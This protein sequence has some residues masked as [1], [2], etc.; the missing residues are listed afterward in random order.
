MAGEPERI[1]AK[2]R[3]LRELLQNRRY[4]LDFYQREY[5]WG[6]RQIAELLEDLTKRFLGDYQEGHSRKDVASYSPYFLGSIV[7]SQRGDTRFLID[8]QQRLTS[9]TLLLI[10]L[11]HSLEPGE[12][13]QIAPLISSVH[14]GEHSFNLDVPERNACM[15][16]LF[17]QEQYDGVDP[18][19]SVANIIARFKDIEEWWSS[20]D[21][22]ARVLPFF[23]D[24]LVEKLILVEIVTSD[25]DMAYEIFET[26]ND[27]GLSLTPTEML[28]GY[29][30]SNLGAPDEVARADD[31]WRDEVQRLGE[32]DK[33]ADADF[34]KSWLRASY[35]ETIR[36]R[37]RDAVPQDYDLVGTQFHR[38]VRDNCESIGLS[39]RAAFARFV[40]RDF[41]RMARHFETIVNASSTLTPGL[42][43]VYY[44]SRLGVPQLPMMLLAPVTPDDSDELAVRKMRIVATF[45][46]IF[47]MRR[48]VNFRNYGYS[49]MY[50]RL[51]IITKEIRGKDPASLV[52]LLLE[53]LEQQANEGDTIAGIS[54]YSLHGRNGHQ[55]RCLLA[56]LTEFVEQQ[57]G[58]EAIGFPAYSTS[59][60]E[61]EHVLANRY[62]RHPEYKSEDEFQRVRNRLGGLVLLPKG[63]NASFQDQPYAE[64]VEHY[65]GQNLLARSLH[66][67]CYRNNPGFSAFKQRSGLAFE[68]IADFDQ[69]AIESRQGLYSA[70]AELIWDS[71]RVAAAAELVG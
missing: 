54:S 11:H 5:R 1:D 61:I 70:L 26:M 47:F 66:P 62:D 7:I 3:S 40:S 64:K 18:N 35:A 6:E 69:A 68:P 30:L 33:A 37:K 21:L 43:D 28:K 16:A 49:P 42:E 58:L 15:A 25:D 20:D 57:S 41:V 59:R 2:A 34:F 45:L 39:N 51:F 19:Q 55:V 50:Y 44:D 22:D 27:R 10:H 8:G 38:W 52:P 14:Y 60:F 71:D 46:D 4:G 36:D 67:L 24:W 53:Q 65:T 32:L 23:A 13:A 63:F 31:V 56:R 9:L 48:V 12:A 29:L 17:E